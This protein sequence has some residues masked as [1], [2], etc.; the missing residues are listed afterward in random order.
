MDAPQP[1]A[2]EQPSQ[3]GVGEKRPREEPPEAPA[4]LGAPTNGEGEDDSPLLPKH[5]VRRAGVDV[6]HLRA[7]GRRPCAAA[8][9]RG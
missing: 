1:A 5:T 7:P 8:G 3:S 6:I 4:T 2:A 9:R